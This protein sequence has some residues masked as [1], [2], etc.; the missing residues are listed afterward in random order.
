MAFDA[1]GQRVASVAEPLL[2]AHHDI[3]AAR[4]SLQDGRRQIRSLVVTSDYG[5]AQ[6]VPFAGFHAVL[7]SE[8][9]LF[10]PP[11]GSWLT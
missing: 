9:E 10:H 6:G 8:I 5:D 11:R 4:Y 1:A 7:I 2:A 3:P